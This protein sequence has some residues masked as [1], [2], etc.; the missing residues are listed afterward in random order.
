MDFPIDCALFLRLTECDLGE[1]GLYK[2]T[3]QGVRSLRSKEDIDD[4][5]DRFPGL[6]EAAGELD[7]IQKAR[8]EFPTTAVALLAWAKHNDEIPMPEWFAGVVSEN[9][10]SA[11]LAL[12]DAAEQKEVDEKE[13]LSSK[14]R[15]LKA[16][17]SK[18]G[19][20]YAV[21]VELRDVAGRTTAIASVRKLIAES[22][23]VLAAVAKRRRSDRMAEEIDLA[24]SQGM[25]STKDIMNWLTS[26]AGKPG[27][28]V[29]DARNDGVI[30]LDRDGDPQF[31][32]MKDLRDREYRAKKRLG[33]A[34]DALRTR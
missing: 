7:F 15:R 23:Q 17:K 11:A 3:T 6:G 22:G 20:W 1:Y 30:W 25:K 33:R 10:A 18:P 26:Q 24:E 21:E 32:S 13:A 9:R 8:L 14:L 19:T 29:R 2:I 4:F 28:C 5:A 31:M 27:S 34:K 16:K 12:L